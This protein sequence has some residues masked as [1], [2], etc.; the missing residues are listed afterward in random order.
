QTF[1]DEARSAMDARERQFGMTQDQIH[2]SLGK[3]HDEVAAMAEGRKSIAQRID[4]ADAQIIGDQETGVHLGKKAR[5]ERLQKDYDREFA[6]SEKR[7]QASRTP[8]TREEA[9]ARLTEMEAAHERLISEAEA[10]LSGG[11]PI[12]KA[13]VA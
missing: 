5:V 2:H 3:A 8:R 9:I 10:T 6:K 1:L 4:E 7:V 11:V 13:E 12:D